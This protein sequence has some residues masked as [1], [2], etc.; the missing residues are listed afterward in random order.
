MT[1]SIEDP[2]IQLDRLNIRPF[3]MDDLNDVIRLWRNCNLIRPWNDPSKDIARKLRV[4]PEWFLVAALGK[5]VVGSIMIGYE[6]HRGWINYLAVAAPFR[7]RGIGTQL[8]REAEAILRA[9]GCPKINLQ[10]R[11][12][13]ELEPSRFYLGLGFRLDEVVC[14]GKRLEVDES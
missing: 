13:N 2:S 7:G 11:V 14:Y 9:I 5:E 1:R 6:G 4:N 3:Q 10:V 12:G 8:M